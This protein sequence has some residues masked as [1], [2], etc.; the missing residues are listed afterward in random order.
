M[1]REEAYIEQEFCP[2]SS[3]LAFALHWMIFCGIT[4]IGHDFEGW[5][6]SCWIGPLSMV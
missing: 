2:V 5:A 3:Q 6:L 4:S 1:L